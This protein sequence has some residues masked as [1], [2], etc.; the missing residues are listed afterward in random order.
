MFELSLLGIDRKAADFYALLIEQNKH[1]LFRSLM[2]RLE[3][4]FGITELP[5]EA[6]VRF[7]KAAQE[8]DESLEDWSDRVM[9]LAS[10]AFKELPS[11]YATQQS[12]LRF[13]F[14]LYDKKS[15]NACFDEAPKDNG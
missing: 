15:R 8:Y 14:G 3:K 9:M 6:Q 10:R 2:Q 4:R 11:S 5:E 7:F 1:S 12:V 13:C